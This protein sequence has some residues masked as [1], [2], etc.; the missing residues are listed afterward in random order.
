MIKLTRSPARLAQ[1]LQPSLAYYCVCTILCRNLQLAASHSVPPSRRYQ[2]T[3]WYQPL[4][5]ERT[6][7]DSH[8]KPG[9]ARF[10]ASFIAVVIRVLRRVL[11]EMNANCTDQ[12]AKFMCMHGTTTRRMVLPPTLR[13]K[14][15]PSGLR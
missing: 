5:T 4:L 10:L 15:Q 8:H 2:P 12:N 11:V 6:P 3:E 9:T 7:D 14:L 13:H 1:V